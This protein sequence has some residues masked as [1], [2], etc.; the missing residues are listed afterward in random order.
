MVS[1]LNVCP[2]D[3]PLFLP[4][5]TGFGDDGTIGISVV[6]KTQKLSFIIKVCTRR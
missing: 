2:H 1:G 6:H 5:L 4:E 3:V